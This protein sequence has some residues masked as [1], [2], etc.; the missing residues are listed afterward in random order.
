VRELLDGA[1]GQ[2][3][4]G[5]LAGAPEVRASLLETIGTAYFQLGLYEQA[6]KHL[7]PAIELFTTA[8]GA[9]DQQTLMAADKLGA[10][11]LYQHKLD[12]AEGVLDRTIDAKK[13][14]LGP[15][16]PDTLVS[17]AHRA[18]LM[19]DR[20]DLAGAADLHRQVIAAKR[21]GI[22]AEQTLADVL[23]DDGKLDEALK[24]VTGAEEA[25]VRTIGADD[26][27]TL[28]VR[29]T[30]ASILQKLGKYAESEEISRA[31]VAGKIRVFGAEHP[32]TFTAQNVLA[33]TLEREGKAAEGVTILT[34]ASEGAARVLGPEHTTTLTYRSNLARALQ[35]SGK[36]G[37][38][39]KIFREVLDAS[40][41]ARQEGDQ[42]T[43]VVQNNLALLLQQ[44]HKADQA[45]PMFAGVYSGL[46]NILPPEHWMLAAS[47]GNWGDCLRELGRFDEAERKLLKAYD[48]LR[49][50]LGP[51]HDRTK[52]TAAAIADLYRD[53]EAAAPGEGRG[54]KERTWRGSAPSPTK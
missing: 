46:K 41:R 8:R 10:A 50:A 12:E 35:L 25:A 51:D 3:A 54:E 17:L 16:H 5:S 52:K 39:E 1:A 36:P 9:E 49:A 21:A 38:A 26:P 47:L 22:G 13:R 37:E 19:Q 33:L 43:L 11:L 6:E 24:V 27:L 23:E 45:E 32:E 44:E 4:A 15:N 30:R 18:M 40:K 42:G 53:W 48:G 20:G 28:T 14:V 2:L 34:Q 31:V 7:R 29:S